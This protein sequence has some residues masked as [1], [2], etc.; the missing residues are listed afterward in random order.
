MKSNA[1]KGCISQCFD[2]HQNQ[3][4]PIL[5]VVWAQQLLSGCIRVLTHVKPTCTNTTH[6]LSSV[7][8]YALKNS[9][10]KLLIHDFRLSRLSLRHICIWKHLIET[11]CSMWLTLNFAVPTDP[12]PGS[13][14]LG[15]LLGNQSRSTADWCEIPTFCQVLTCPITSSTQTHKGQSK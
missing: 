2:V 12:S 15:H 10:S 9:F 7:P 13:L 11:Y 14:S 8:L 5:W 3:S 1:W 6:R 4:L